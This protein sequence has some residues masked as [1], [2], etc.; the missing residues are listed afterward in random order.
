MSAFLFAEPALR[1]ERRAGGFPLTLPIAGLARSAEGATPAEPVRS[2]VIGAGHEKTALGAP[3][4]RPENRR[5]APAQRGALA[6]RLVA[7]VR[8][9]SLGCWRRPSAL[10]TFRDRS[11]HAP[12]TC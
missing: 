6:E 2:G 10:P 11:A 9:L 8:S 12:Q 7:A 1:D 4:Q 3:R 5:L